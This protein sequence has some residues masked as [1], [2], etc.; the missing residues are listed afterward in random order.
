MLT[1]TGAILLLALSVLV[2]R[3]ASDRFPGKEEQD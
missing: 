3:I 1:I 2:V